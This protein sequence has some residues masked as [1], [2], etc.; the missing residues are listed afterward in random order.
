MRRLRLAVL[1]LVAALST[2]ARAEPILG[3]KLT[4]RDPGT[5]EDRRSVVIVARETSTDVG[6]LGDPTVGGAT[7][8]ILADGAI[9]TAAS[10]TL[11]ATGWTAV[12]NGY[13]Y[14]GP[15][16][17]DPVRRVLLRRTT[18]GVALLKVVMRGNTG[19]QSLDLRPPAPGDEARVVLD[20]T[21][22]DRHCVTFGGAAGGTE[23]QDTAT[24]WTVVDATA[25]PACP[26]ST[27]P[28][29]AGEF[30]PCGGCGDGI[31]VH[32]A[33]GLPAFFCA[34]QSGYSAG[35]CTTSAECASPRDCSIPPNPPCPGTTG[36]CVLPCTGDAVCE[37]AAAGFCA[38]VTCIGEACL[39]PCW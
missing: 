7:I 1:V 24:R 6:T 18:S 26:T 15:T 29:C 22:G 39:Q 27:L 19:T 13:R 34:S 36:E 25:Q 17:G 32:H 12:A 4:I 14:V 31:C 28:P 38:S 3:R 37:S 16:S 2:D 23:R 20:V 5:G 35:T 10:Y 33:S 9:S 21:G 11:D 8:Q 30:T